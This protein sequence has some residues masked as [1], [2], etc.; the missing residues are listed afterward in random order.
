MQTDAVKIEGK[1]IAITGILTFYKR[2]EAFELIKVKGGIPQNGVTRE[3]D[4]LVVGYYH[5]S[6]PEFKSKKLQTA[7]R[8]I[9]KG[10]QIRILKDE[11]FTMMIWME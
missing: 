5:I 3:T 4:I 1:H 8:Y 11:E 9:S 10:Y 2:Q 6:D 7:E